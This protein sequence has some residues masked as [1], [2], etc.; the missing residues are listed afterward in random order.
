MKVRGV[1]VTVIIRLHT[2][3]LSGYGNKLTSPYT[4]TEWLRKQTDISIHSHWVATE[5]NWHLH[6]LTLSGY[7]NKLTS[8]YTH[9]EWLRKQT[10]ISIH[11]HWV[12]TETNWHLHTLT[13]S[14]YGNKLTSPYTHTEWLRKQTDI[15][16]HSHWVATEK[17]SRGRRDCGLS[18]SS[19]P[20]LQSWWTEG[21]W[22][23]VPGNLV[24]RIAICFPVVTSTAAE[25]DDHYRLLQGCVFV[26]VLFMA[27]CF[28]L[29]DSS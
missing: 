17:N 4:H 7:G 25:R 21:F 9:T 22:C 15:S 3:T 14:G 12:A 1:L 8:P 27:F 18:Q 13:L 10:D 20:Q 2:L 6:T 19:V 28:P 24:N 23:F 11:S 26:C 29:R 16:I 5:T